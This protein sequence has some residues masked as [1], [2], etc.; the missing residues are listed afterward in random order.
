MK[1]YIIVIFTLSISLLSIYPQGSFVDVNDVKYF[2]SVPL[3]D[4]NF[5]FSILNPN[6]DEQRE[7][8][9]IM[10]ALGEVVK[11]VNLEIA[12]AAYDQT[13]GSYIVS[14]SKIKVSYDAN[15]MEVFFPLIKPIQLVK[16]KYGDVI[17]VKIPSSALGSVWNNYNKSELPNFSATTI[18]DSTNDKGYPAWFLKPP[19]QEGYIFGVGVYSKVSKITDLFINADTTARA[20]V[21]RVLKIKVKTEFRDFIEDNFEVTDFFNNKV[22]SA[23]LGG[24]YIVRRFFNEKKK[25]AYS[26]AVLKL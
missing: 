1:R 21:V 11:F 5:Y 4:G 17:T 18:D 3:D 23:N 12:F 16:T 2:S 6:Y 15:L 14:D 7:K 9:Y 19:E 10:N 24:I 22:A 26:L 20:E 8:Q 25:I 13:F